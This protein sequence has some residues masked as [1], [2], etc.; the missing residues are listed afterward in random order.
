[1][2]FSNNQVYLFVIRSLTV[3]NLVVIRFSRYFKKTV[4]LYFVFMGFVLFSV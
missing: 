4:T 3:K 2:S 1:M